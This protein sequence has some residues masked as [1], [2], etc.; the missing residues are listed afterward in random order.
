MGVYSPTSRRVRRGILPVPTKP[1]R[2]RTLDSLPP[3]A[4]GCTEA[5]MLA[6]GFTVEQMVELVRAGLAEAER[7]IAAGWRI[8]TARVRITDAGWR[9]LGDWARVAGFALLG[10]WGI[11]CR[12]L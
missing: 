7:V 5:V 10:L 11:L 2:R 1:D 9:A 12:T 4:T 8:E 3:V 6:H